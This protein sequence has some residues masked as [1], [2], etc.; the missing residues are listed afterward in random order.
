MGDSNMRPLVQIL[1]EQLGL[2]ACTYATWKG[3]RYTTHAVCDDAGNGY[4]L[5]YAFVWFKG[6]RYGNA[7]DYDSV[8]LASLSRFI[9]T[10]PFDADS[11]RPP[12]SV[13]LDIPL[14]HL[15][16]TTGSHLPQLS[17]NGM[18]Q[19]LDD[20]RAAFERKI[21][22]AEATSFASV[23]SVNPAQIPAQFGNQAAMR[24]NVMIAR[25]NAAQKEW[26]QSAFDRRKVD[27][28]DLFS[29]SMV[30]PDSGRRD[31]I[32]FHPFVYDEWA[33]IFVA[34]MELARRRREEGQ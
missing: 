28:L 12:S 8:D 9:A 30:V 23:A 11:P 5:T 26:I 10:M 2:G 34:T 27:F 21:G 15:F 18:R 1:Q 24:N 4:I 29:M 20:Y 19:T 3:E 32:H 22:Q 31:A 25:R 17:A 33:R 6:P 7:T 13:M 16:I 14:T